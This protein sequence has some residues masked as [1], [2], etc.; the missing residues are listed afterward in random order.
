VEHVQRI[1]HVLFE[2]APAQLL[3]GAAVF[4]VCNEVAQSV[5]RTLA[6]ERHIERQ[7]VLRELKKLADS[8]GC[9]L[10]VLGD[11]ARGWISSELLLELVDGFLDIADDGHH[12]QRHAHGACL[13]R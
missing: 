4:L 3:Q 6:S 8:F 9:E 13:V 12:V 2:Q 5:A 11:F 7:G 1:T 10:G